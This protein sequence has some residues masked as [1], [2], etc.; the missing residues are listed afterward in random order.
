MS[1]VLIRKLGL[2]TVLGA[3]LGVLACGTP[4][5]GD[6]LTPAERQ[7][8]DGHR[9][10]LVL[11]VEPGYAPFVFTDA[12]GRTTGLAND[13][14]ALL[15][16]KLGTRFE[17]KSVATLDEILRQARSGEIQVVNAVSPTPDR[18]EYLAFTKP[19]IRLP[20]AILV[21]AERS[22]A[23]DEAHLRGL[24]VSLV[25]SYAIT[26]H[27]QRKDL[28]LIPDLVPD[29]LSALLEVSLGRSDAAVLDLATA[30]Y[31]IEAKG[32]TNLRVAGVADPDIQ[33]CLAS[34]RSEAVL[35]GILEKGLGAI[36]PGERRAIRDRWIHLTH[37][38]MLGDWRFRVLALGLAA[39]ALGAVILVLAWNRTLRHQ[40]ELRTQAL[41]LEKQALHE[42]EG[43]N[44]AL[45][46]AIPDLIFTNRGDGTFLSVHASDPGLLFM[47]PEAFLGQGLDK[48]LPGPV[49]DRFLLAFSAALDSRKVQELTY[50][51][52]TGGQTRQFEARVAPSSV[53][54]VVTIIRDIT[55]RREAEAGL[56]EQAEALRARNAA[57]SQFNRVTVGR[58]LRMIEL[59][60]EVNGLCAQLGLPPRYG[61]VEDETLPGSQP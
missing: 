61:K 27:L 41:A 32:I 47:P 15:E 46:S 54:T 22:G 8:L 3:L 13:Y 31:L 34:P 14:M 16:A 4:R 39:L 50:K 1:P 36:T 48:V 60:R 35:H 51:V 21:R 2:A 59:K 40:V 52:E 29:D 11:A 42:S 38:N 57:L 28:G 58:E 43:R 24:R 17:R 12:E 25:R 7:W 9:G 19:F 5:A 6:L 33:L 56:R 18:L 53:G 26:E 49:A 20:N 37:P 10:R 55:E 30:S 23:M 44:L 45:I